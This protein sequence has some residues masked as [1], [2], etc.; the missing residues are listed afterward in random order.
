MGTK[1][2]IFNIQT[3]SIHDGP[4]IRTVVFLKGC[5]LRCLWCSNPE[6]Q[7]FEKQVYYSEIRCIQCGS[8]VN[9][10]PNQ[11]ISIKED[12]T[13]VLNRNGCTACGACA[14]E[15]PTNAIKI[16]GREVDSEELIDEIEKERNYMME[17]GGGVTFSGGEP[18]AQACFLFECCKL[19]K[20]RGYH[21]AVETCGEVP[22]YA[23]EK[24]LP[25]IDLILFDL[26]AADGDLHRRLTGKSNDVVLEN[27]FKLACNF[28]VIV[29]IPVVPGLNDTEKEWSGIANRIYR[30]NPNISVHLLPYHNLG[31]AK[32]KSLNRVYGIEHTKIPND[33]QMNRMK[34]IFE[35]TG[36]SCEIVQ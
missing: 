6:S 25:Y 19:L 22:F 29:R 2:T 8:C 23:I 20:K 4:G 30:A 35:K 13:V 10:C 34:E 32:Y 11:L 5:P 14:A 18:F 28:N 24:S 9:A 1:G 26:K 3:Y 36:L 12:G 21:I 15:C 27:F 17:S 7:L 31:M 33:Y 16:A